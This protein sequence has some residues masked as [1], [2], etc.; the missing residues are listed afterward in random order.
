VTVS[1]IDAN[2]RNVVFVAKR[3]R[4]LFCHIHI[5]DI[6]QPVCIEQNR[7]SRPDQNQHHHNA[8]SDKCIAAARKKLR[9]LLKSLD[10]LRDLFEELL[11]PSQ[12][13]LQ[14]NGP[15]S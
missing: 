1:T 5:G 15:N 13:K 8:D 12:K 4:L 7:K 14:Y 2:T 3:H 6:V 9:H 11:K 10:G